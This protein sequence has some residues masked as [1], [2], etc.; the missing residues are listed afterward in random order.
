M[1][2]EKY[3]DPCHICYRT[4]SYRPTSHCHEKFTQNSVIITN[5]Y[6]NNNNNNNNK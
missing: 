4:L 3:D 2:Y 1:K 5:N 6:N